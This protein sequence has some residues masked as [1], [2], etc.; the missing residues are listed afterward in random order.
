VRCRSLLDNGPLRVMWRFG[1]RAWI[2]LA[3][4]HLVGMALGVAMIPVPSPPP[5]A[6]LTRPRQSE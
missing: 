4:G 5:V 6:S 2:A 1:S 3:A